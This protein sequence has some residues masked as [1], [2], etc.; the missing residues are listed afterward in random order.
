MVAIG[1]SCFGLPLAETISELSLPHLGLGLGV[2]SVD[3]ALVPLLS[4]LVEQNGSDH[5]GPIYALQQLSVAV[6]YSFGP[7]IAG[8]AVQNIGFPWL[9]RIVG[10]LNLI[11]CPLLQELELNNVSSKKIFL[12]VHTSIKIGIYFREEL[13]GKQ[14]YNLF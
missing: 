3:A 1:L 8:Q 14:L 9:I 4:F 11:T 10:F 2:G 13:A 7:L 12:K 5:Y 6:A